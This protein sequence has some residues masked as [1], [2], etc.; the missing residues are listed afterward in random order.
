MGTEVEGDAGSKYAIDHEGVANHPNDFGMKWIAN[1][2][3]CAV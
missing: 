3:L 2:I 1:G